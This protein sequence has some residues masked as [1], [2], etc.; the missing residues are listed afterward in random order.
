MANKSKLAHA[1]LF[2]GARYAAM[3]Q[4][5]FSKM[6]T[7]SI[8]SAGSLEQR[9]LFLQKYCPCADIL[10]YKFLNPL[11]LEDECDAGTATRRSGSL[12]SYNRGSLGSDKA[13]A[14]GKL[15]STVHCSIY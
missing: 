6:Q 7:D 5:K 1:I 4:D 11:G 13:S 10:V 14:K 15:F 2:I 9:V 8:N 3:A 12:G